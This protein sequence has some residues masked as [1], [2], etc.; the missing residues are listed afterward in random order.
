M[1]KIG[2]I[3]KLRQAPSHTQCDIMW[4]EG[5]GGS[6]IDLVTHAIC[7]ASILLYWLSAWFFGLLRQYIYTI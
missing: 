6:T 2:G 4:Q 5:G 1:A 3:Q 7:T